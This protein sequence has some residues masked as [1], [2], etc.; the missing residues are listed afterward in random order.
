MSPT[1]IAKYFFISGKTCCTVGGKASCCEA[2]LPQM[3]VLLSSTNSTV[4]NAAGCNIYINCGGTCCNSGALGCCTAY[5]Y[6]ECCS[7]NMCCPSGARCCGSWCCHNN[8]RCGINYMTCY[9]AAAGLNPTTLM[10][11]VAVW[12]AAYMVTKM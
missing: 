2:E 7:N 8:A 4:Q 3:S 12:L 11:L 10:T 1:Y 5:K 6:A 9:N